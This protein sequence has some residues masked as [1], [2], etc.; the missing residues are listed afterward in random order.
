MDIEAFLL[1]KGIFS[2]K[3]LPHQI[4]KLYMR[5]NNL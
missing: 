1:E 2:Y 3:L 4:I 5:V